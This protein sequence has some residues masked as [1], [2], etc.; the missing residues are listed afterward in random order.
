M[1]ATH[2][3]KVEVVKLLS[4][5]EMRIQTWQKKRTAFSIACEM[6]SEEIALLLVEEADIVD[7]NGWN[8]LMWAAKN[9]LHKVVEILVPTLK[10]KQNKS[11]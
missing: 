5:Q 9:G 2:A 10:G 3:N 8:G 4:T 7:E 1:E 11:G 6:K